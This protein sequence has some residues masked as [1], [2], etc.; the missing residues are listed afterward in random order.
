MD[1]FTREQWAAVGAALG[2]TFHDDEIDWR[3][4]SVS[5]SGDKCMPLAYLNARAVMERFDTVVGAGNWSDSYRVVRVGPDTGVEC[6]LTVG[7]ITKVDVGT[8]SN[9]DPVKGAYSDA[10]KRAA[11]RFGIGRYLYSMKAVWVGYTGKSYDPFATKDFQKTHWK[12]A[13]APPPWPTEKLASALVGTVSVPVEPQPATDGGNLLLER[14]MAE[15][16]MRGDKLG[17]LMS[18]AVDLGL[19]DEQAVVERLKAAGEAIGQNTIV[20]GSHEIESP[21]ELEM[22]ARAIV[23]PW[24]G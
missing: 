23:A 15:A 16:V 24:E 4:G 14:L 1:N 12:S 20:R 8:P 11:A 2:S 5:K 13:G 18:A 21:D 7:G 19:G 10:L 3:V 17:H 9:T 22:W 6:S